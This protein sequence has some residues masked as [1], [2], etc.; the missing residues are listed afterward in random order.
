MTIT[1]GIQQFPNDDNVNS[2]HSSNRIVVV[3]CN[4]EIDKKY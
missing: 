2:C 3:L 1:F 4:S